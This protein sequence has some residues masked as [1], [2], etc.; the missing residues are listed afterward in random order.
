LFLSLPSGKLADRR[1]KRKLLILTNTLAGSAALTLGILVITDLV[2]VW[3]VMVLAVMLGIASAVDAPIRQSFV[4][5][6]VGKEDLPNAI[7]LNAAN[8]NAGRLVGPAAAGLLIAAFGTGPAFIINALTYPIVITALMMMNTTTLHNFGR[9][10]KS[11]GVRS[12]LRYVK[13]RPDL[14][15]TMILVLIV[16][17]FGFNFQVVTALMARVEFGLGATSFGLFGTMIA[18]GTVTGA[19]VVARF[20]E[21]PKLDFILKAAIA[22]GVIEIV[23]SQMPTYWMFA[24]V[25]PLAGYA[26]MM[27]MASA[28][29]YIQSTV[30]DMLRGRVTGLYLM[31]FMGGSPV[32]SPII[33]KISQDF[34]ARFG[35]AIGGIISALAAFVIW[36]WFRRQNNLVIKQFSVEEPPI[37]S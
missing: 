3:H 5:E 16:G 18:L 24:A 8:F 2:Q 6:L 14:V 34:G 9:A 30:P 32:G 21:A 35:L 26:A 1:N 20:L 37:I 23:A 31:V 15:A 28:N 10:S 27:V 17:A 29:S 33:G 22:F 12:A 19:V 4:P 7:G 13:A 36:I 11:D 25:L